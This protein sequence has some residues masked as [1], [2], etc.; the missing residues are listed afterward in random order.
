MVQKSIFC[1]NGGATVKVHFALHDSPEGATPV[2]PHATLAQDVTGVVPYGVSRRTKSVLP[3]MA[4]V[5]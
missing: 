2:V 1:V 5:H 4:M 3:P